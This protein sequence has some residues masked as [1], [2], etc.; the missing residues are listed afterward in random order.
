MPVVVVSA[1]YLHIP[2]MC[3]CC[4]ASPDA[5][6]TDRAFHRAARR[7]HDDG[8]QLGFPI[9]RGCLHHREKETSIWGGSAPRSPAC[10]G[11]GRLV[12]YVS[13]KGTEHTIRFD[14]PRYAL[15]LAEANRAAGRNVLRCDLSAYPAPTARRSPV[16]VLALGVGV[17]MAAAC[18]LSS[19]SRQDSDSRTAAPPPMRVR[20]PQPAAPAPPPTDAG[21]HHRHRR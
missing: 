14:S 11:R 3:V 7:T 17:L 9:C 6:I 12:D 4:G 8:K 15:A 21:R 20:V 18:C 10:E 19:M 16:V 1:V 5:T 2:Q 13:W